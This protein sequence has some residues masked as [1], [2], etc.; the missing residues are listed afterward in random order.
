MS[1]STIFGL[2]AFKY[3]YCVVENINLSQPLPWD[4]TNLVP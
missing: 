1:V 2:S 3:F 4:K